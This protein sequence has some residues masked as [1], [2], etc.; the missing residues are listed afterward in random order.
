[1]SKKASKATA[2]KKSKGVHFAEVDLNE[3]TDI[4]E[5]VSDVSRDDDGSEEE[6]EEE[7]EP[8]EFIDL[9]DILDGRGDPES[10]DDMGEVERE[11][12]TDRTGQAHDGSGD[13]PEQGDETEDEDHSDDEHVHQS[14]PELEDEANADPSAL[15]HLGSFITNLDAGTKRKAPEDNAEEQSEETKRR[16][17]RM[18]KEQTQ[19][20]IESEFAA[21]TGPHPHYHRESL[22][23]VPQVQAN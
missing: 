10:E 6:E 14:D 18:L 7:G 20:G 3:D 17:R 12:Q 13:D 4:E 23:T 15:D 5:D 22:L 9:L 2:Q 21:Q 8:S 1:M 16:K 19:N 11:G